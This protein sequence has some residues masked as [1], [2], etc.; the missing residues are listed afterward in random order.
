[1]HSYNDND[2]GWIYYGEY[3]AECVAAL[4]DVRVVEF[5]HA[6][7]AVKLLKDVIY[8]YLDLLA[9]LVGKLG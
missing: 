1:M 8:A 3:L 9:D 6:D 4:G 2:M 5:A 7:G